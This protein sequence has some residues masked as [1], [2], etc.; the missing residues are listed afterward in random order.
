MFL[1]KKVRNTYFGSVVFS[2]NVNGEESEQNRG[3]KVDKEKRKQE[4]RQQKKQY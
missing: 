1:G 3:R 2:L 4:Q